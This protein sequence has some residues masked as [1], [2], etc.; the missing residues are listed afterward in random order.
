MVEKLRHMVLLSWVTYAASTFDGTKD[1]MEALR[2]K[3]TNL[4]NELEVNI[5]LSCSL[6]SY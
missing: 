4:A 6:K 5:I 1:I 2:N 3:H